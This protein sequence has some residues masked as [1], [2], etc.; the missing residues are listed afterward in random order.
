VVKIT[1]TACGLGVE[2]SGWV[3]RDGVVVTNAHVVAGEDDTKVQLGGQGPRLDATPIAFD[4][5]NDIAL[6]RVDGLGARP[7][8]MRSDPPSGVSAAI[9]GFPEN[10]PLDIRA[11]RIGAARTVSTQDAYGRGPVRRRIVPLRGLVRSG[12]SGGPMIDLRGRVVTTV[13]AATVGGRQAG[14][15]GVPNSIVERDIADANGRVSTGPC[16]R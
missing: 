4:P 8:P 5:H 14:G 6:L 9:V 13:F 10:G 1:G 16:A 11:G 7:L 15:Y 2:G 3:A 12:N